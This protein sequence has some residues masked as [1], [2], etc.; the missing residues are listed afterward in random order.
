MALPQDIRP[1]ND[2]LADSITRGLETPWIETKPGMAW[3][4]VLWVG[5]ES[6]R[7]AVLLAILSVI[8]GL[9]GGLL[10]LAISNQTFMRLVPWLLLLATSL[11]ALSAQVSRIIRWLKQ[12]LRIAT[13]ER[14]GSIDRKSTRLNS[15]HRT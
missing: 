12:R 6:G 15:S 2:A 7:W 13:A 11:F 14:P 4:K 8:G 1:V 10:L 9:L 5:Q 3:T